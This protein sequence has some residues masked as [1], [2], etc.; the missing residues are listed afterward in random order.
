MKPIFQKLA[1]F[2]LTLFLAV[3]CGSNNTN[4]ASGQSLVNGVCTANSAYTGTSCVSGQVLTQQGCLS[5]NVQLCGYSAGWNGSSCIPEVSGTTTTT[6]NTGT[7]LTA[8]ATD[9]WNKYRQCGN[10]MAWGNQT[11]TCLY[12][13]VYSPQYMNCISPNQSGTVAQ[14]GTPYCTNGWRYVN[15][16]PTCW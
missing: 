10:Y 6:T 11:C 14:P 12:G 4:C 16:V 2:A 13:L 9:Y 1:V 5:Q 8:D 15:G 3:A 7:T